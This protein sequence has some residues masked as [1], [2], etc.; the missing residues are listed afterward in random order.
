[1]FINVSKKKGKAKVSME[2]NK[3]NKNNKTIIN[4]NNI[5]EGLLVQI[6][7][8]KIKKYLFFYQ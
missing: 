3:N 5:S 4:S 1:V 6:I 2:K 8:I 7:K